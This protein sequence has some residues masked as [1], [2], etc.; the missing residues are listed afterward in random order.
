MININKTNHVFDLL[1]EGYEFDKKLT[2]AWFEMSN[3]HFFGR[4]D[5]KLCVES[6]NYLTENIVKNNNIKIAIG[7]QDEGMNKITHG[8][9]LKD[10]SKENVFNDVFKDIP[11]IMQRVFEQNI[12]NKNTDNTSTPTFISTPD[13]NVSYC[14]FKEIT[15]KDVYGEDCSLQCISSVT[16]PRLW[17]GVDEKL[18]DLNQE[19]VK[20]L[21]PYLQNFVKTGELKKD[22]T[23]KYK[24]LLHEN[25]I[26]IDVK[27]KNSTCTSISF[28]KIS[29]IEEASYTNSNF[30][31]SNNTPEEEYFKITTYLNNRLNGF[32]NNKNITNLPNNFLF[33]KEAV[34]YFS[35][36]DEFKGVIFYKLGT[37]NEKN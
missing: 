14:N 26:A 37:T 20:M 25:N 30:I 17:L 29:T 10:I 18:M 12:C 16:E 36:Q 9:F 11:I 1:K 15:F 6:I 24:Y 33:T 22:T 34:D 28:N 23:I 27:D 31:I 21:L 32:G 7:W 8:I 2:E 5:E 4:V 3:G 13:K 19:H 35:K